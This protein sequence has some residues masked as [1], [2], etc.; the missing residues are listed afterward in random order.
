MK[1]GLQRHDRLASEK[2]SD[3]GLIIMSKNTILISKQNHCSC[4]PGYPKVLEQ[5]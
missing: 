2:R 1:N 4:R 5:A 3:R